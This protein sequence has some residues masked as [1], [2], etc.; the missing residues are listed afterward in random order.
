MRL[1]RAKCATND[2]LVQGISSGHICINHIRARRE[3]GCGLRHCSVHR[4][5]QT[6]VRHFASKDVMS[7][8]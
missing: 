5:V 8:N 2:V 4:S 1:K 3:E 7:V 6:A